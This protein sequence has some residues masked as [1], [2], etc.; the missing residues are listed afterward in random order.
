M[1]ILD[2]HHQA[3]LASR[4]SVELYTHLYFKNKKLVED[5]YI[6]RILKNGVSVLIPKYGIE[7]IVY[8]NEW[9]HVSE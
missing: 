9:V 8:G 6:V 2:R 3:Q 4:S 5:A 7:G 1:F